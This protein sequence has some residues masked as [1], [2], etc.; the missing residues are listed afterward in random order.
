M[1]TL[2]IIGNGFDIAHG[3]KTKYSE[4]F[5]WYLNDISKKLN[6]DKKYHDPLITISK[7]GAFHDSFF[8]VKDISDFKR[9]YNEGEG[10]FYSTKFSEYLFNHTNDPIWVDLEYAYFNSL[11]E[12]YSDYFEKYKSVIPPSRTELIN[13]AIEEVRKLNN[14]CIFLKSK[15]EEYLLTIDSLTKEVNSE[16]LQHFTQEFSIASDIP[17][18]VVSPIM[19]A[20]LILN[21]NYTSTLEVYKQELSGYNL[22]INYIHGKLKDELNP[23]VF[24]YGDEVNPYYKLIENLNNNEFL[25][26]FKS[27]SY[28]KTENYIKLIN[29]LNGGNFKVLIMG[30]SCGLSDR[31]LLNSIF[32]NRNCR[33]IKIFYHKKSLTENDFFEKTQEISRHFNNKEKM[34]E[35]IT[36]FFKSSPLIS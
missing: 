34:R 4:F 30:H 16:I 17:K 15:L 36:P 21:F 1:N 12:I 2:V 25:N 5:L 14:I 18:G 20:N 10:K 24:G 22:N 29:F 33:G 8:D 27:F 11:T 23:L 26:N 6:S 7:F 19:D 31:V 32:E 28:F 13:L 3:L 35:K 9:I